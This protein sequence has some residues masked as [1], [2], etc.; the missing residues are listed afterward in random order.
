MTSGKDEATSRSSNGSTSADSTSRVAS[1]S[2]AS[3]ETKTPLTAELLSSESVLYDSDDSG[4]VSARAVLFGPNVPSRCPK[5]WRRDSGEDVSSST[6]FYPRSSADTYASSMTSSGCL[7]HE[8]EVACDSVDGGD[9]RILP[10][11]VY[12]REIVEPSIRPSTPH[13]FG[14]LFPSLNRL[15]IRHDEFTSDGNMNLRVDTVLTG[16]R[17][18]AIQLFHLRM[19]DLARREFSLRRY[20]RDSGREVCN[21]KRLYNEHAASKPPRTEDGRSSLQRSVTSAIK[22]LGRGARSGSFRRADTSP[23]VFASPTPGVA[24]S[25]SDGRCTTQ[26][27]F[28]SHASLESIGLATPLSKPRRPRPTNSIKLEFSNYAR[29]DVALRGGRG[30]RRY[31]F[32]WW[33]HRY[34]WMR[35]IRR[36]WRGVGPHAA[37]SDASFRLERDGHS[38]FPVAFIVPETRSPNQVAAD[39]D[40]GGWVPPCFMWIADEGVLGALTDVAE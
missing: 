1:T 36:A 30:H 8:H 40:A 28:C 4:K 6:S 18:T 38:G 39:D 29:V 23:P 21:S 5:E 20:C 16:R 32:D 24:S 13:E 7:Y 22:T 31:E 33:G 14:R 3:T 10:L 27:S 17:R 12:R 34:S 9:E 37:K 35:E 19:H 26:T 25:P 2:C 11:P 15:S